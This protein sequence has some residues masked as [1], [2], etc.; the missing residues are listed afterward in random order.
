MH[1]GFFI[2][3]HT[4]VR[5]PLYPPPPPPP[6]RIRTDGS[7]CNGCIKPGP[8]DTPTTRTPSAYQPF[9]WVHVRV[10]ARRR[11]GPQRRGLRA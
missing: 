8:I 4:R 2:E 3:K 7:L 5:V 10:A 6:H 9:G 1:L 11:V